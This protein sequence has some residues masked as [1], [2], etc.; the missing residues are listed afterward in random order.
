MSVGLNEEA[1]MSTNKMADIDKDYIQ[2]IQRMS[3]L[4]AA[5]GYNPY[6]WMEFG[7]MFNL[8]KSN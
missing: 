7:L 1:Y 6:G 8:G 5:I 4:F 2:R 3:L